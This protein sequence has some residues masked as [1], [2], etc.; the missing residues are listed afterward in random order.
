MG[1]VLSFYFNPNLLSHALQ[2][3]NHACV[4]SL[5]RNAF[6]NAKKDWNVNV[7]LELVV[8]LSTNVLSRRS[9]AQVISTCRLTALNWH[10][11]Y[12]S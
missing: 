11:I 3:Y 2:F 10:R 9:Q 6:G 4:L 7:V 8:L 12:G 5:N 1:N